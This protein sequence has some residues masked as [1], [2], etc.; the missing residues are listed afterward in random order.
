MEKIIETIRTFLEFVGVSILKGELYT[1]STTWA[2]MLVC[3]FIIFVIA[4][5]IDEIDELDNNIIL[6]IIF[7]WPIVGI[8]VILI[9][10]IATGI[11][12]YLIVF[13]KYLWN[14]A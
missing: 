10:Y 1:H 4:I 9:T 8:W 13:I 5:F 3:A 12:Y 14:S 2:I 7:K 11:F 6:K